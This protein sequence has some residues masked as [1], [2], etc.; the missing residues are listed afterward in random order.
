MF[1]LNLSSRLII[2]IILVTSHTHDE[3]AA[4]YQAREARDACGFQGRL[5][6]S[7]T[8]N[9]ITGLQATSSSSCK[10]AISGVQ[11]KSTYFLNEIVGEEKTVWIGI[12]TVLYFILYSSK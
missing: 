4:L 5:R 3:L 2:L 6:V 1:Y 7:Q 10:F 9:E 11:S 8:T 12:F